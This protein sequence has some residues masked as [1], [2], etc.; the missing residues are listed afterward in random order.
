MDLLRQ[1]PY[2]IDMKDILY[3][4]ARLFIHE[5]EATAP[6]L[7]AQ[8]RIGYALA[9]ATM[10]E[11]EDIGIISEKRSGK[12]KVLVADIG[13]LTDDQRK[14]LRGSNKNGHGSTAGPAESGQSDPTLLTRAALSQVDFSK[15]I[16]A[17]YAEEGAMGCCG[18]A[19]AYVL[20]GDALNLYR[21]NDYTDSCVYKQVVAEIRNHSELFDYCYGGF[22]NHVHIRKFINLSVDQKKEQLIFRYGDKQFSINASVKGVFD[23][24]VEFLP[25]RQMK[26]A[27][28][29]SAR[30]LQD[31]L[32]TQPIFTKYFGE[33]G[34]NYYLQSRGSGGKYLRSPSY[35]M[36]V[37]INHVVN[38]L[39]RINPVSLIQARIT[40]E[41]NGAKDSRDFSVSKFI[42]DRP[43]HL[44]FLDEE[45]LE[46]AKLILEFISGNDIDMAHPKSRVWADAIIYIKYLNHMASN[47]TEEQI[48]NGKQALRVY[49][50]C[51]LIE[52]LGEQGLNNAINEFFAPNNFIAGV[53]NFYQ[54][55]NSKLG[56]GKIEEMF[57]TCEEVT[58]EDFKIDE[59]GKERLRS[60]WD[61]PVVMRFSDKMDSAIVQEISNGN[62]DDDIADLY[63]NNYD[64]V[65]DKKPYSTIYPALKY[66]ATHTSRYDTLYMVGDI[67]NNIWKNLPDDDALQAWFRKEIHEIY[68][69]R[70]ESVWV[71]QNINRIS[72]IG[73][74]DTSSLLR[75][76]DSGD[77]D[78]NRAIT[79]DAITWVMCLEDI[80]SLNPEIA[81]YL[82]TFKDKPMD[83]LAKTVIEP[84]WK[85][86]FDDRFGS[87]SKSTAEQTFNAI[88]KYCDEN[89]LNRLA[90][91]DS[92]EEARVLLDD[93]FTGNKVIQKSEEWVAL[94]ILEQLVLNGNRKGIG[95]Y[96]F[97]RFTDDFGELV[98]FLEWF[99][100][101]DGLTYG[102]LIS[103]FSASCEGA[104][105][106][107]EYK[108]LKELSSKILELDVDSSQKA[109]MELMVS[110]ALKTAKQNIDRYQFQQADLEKNLQKVAKKY[111][112]RKAS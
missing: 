19:T 42:H 8:L 63:L 22:G 56:N 35:D 37:H 4:A 47:L 107:D 65:L 30:F 109:T 85:R 105:E 38:E 89:T 73:E 66:I 16:Y 15:I 78:G 93:L 25:T 33:I 71:I 69:P 97:H 12:R 43:Y 82:E 60:L 31:H 21:A 23:Q 110:N 53:G 45:S 103:I 1:T 49:R 88:L 75:S 50:L 111:A 100:D 10:D 41:L 58:V 87:T 112:Q 80:S 91:V 94:S 34:L 17:E 61:K 83:Q 95:S 99:G 18:T 11:L 102:Y 108:P 26:T 62:L 39:N 68:W 96:I 51:H 9:A 44:A 40:D 24:V 3:S 52:N 101:F 67:L 59:D 13:D 76:I 90:Y 81:D 36:D 14:R 92:I 54:F 106:L 74:L 104:T 77:A 20:E 29:Y 70:I 48:L 28:L 5:Q 98:N 46:L 32:I 86:I 72:F 7:Q 27:E 55:M 79:Q 84:V 57:T 64:K 2:N 6:L